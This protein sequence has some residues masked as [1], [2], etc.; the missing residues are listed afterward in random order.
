MVGAGGVERGQLHH[1]WP[2][3]MTIEA[4]P[5]FLASFFNQSAAYSDLPIIGL[6]IVLEGVLSIDNALVLGLLAKRLPKHQQSKALTYG[7][8]GAFVF[9]LI[10]IALATYLLRWWFVKLAGGGY[11][12]YVAVKHFLFESK[13]QEHVTSGPDASPVLVLEDGV[14]SLPSDQEEAEISSRS[15]VSFSSGRGGGRAIARFWPTVFVIEMTDIAFA[16]DSI[17][18]AIALVSGVPHEPGQVHPKLWVVMVGGFL[19]VILMR[20]AAVIFIR[21]LERF[22]GFEAAAYLLVT[23]IGC[24]LLA[25]WWFNKPPADLPPGTVFQGPLD[26]HSIHSPAFWVFW[27]LML[28]CFIVGF[29]PRKPKAPAASGA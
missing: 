27:T 23:V 9:R 25:D 1:H 14:T 8:V 12:V 10:A 13:D 5:S 21:L 17:L 18:A 26:F 16:I 29:L 15:P 7:L 19:G 28:L 20:F 4:M 2:D 22:P 11:L 3:N 6:L 24:K